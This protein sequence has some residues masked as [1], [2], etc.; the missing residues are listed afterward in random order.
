MRDIG[1]LYRPS[2][3]RKSQKA[4]I[5]TKSE[6]PHRFLIATLGAFAIR[7]PGQE[8]RFTEKGECAARTVT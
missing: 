3:H 1:K 4:P 8:F 7:G 6:I 5:S 2:P